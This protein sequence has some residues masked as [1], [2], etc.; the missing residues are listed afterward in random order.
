G[1]DSPRF[2]R[3]ADT[4]GAAVA[5]ASSNAFLE[6]NL[7]PK[8]TDTPSSS[9]LHRKKDGPTRK[10]SVTKHALQR[11]RLRSKSASGRDSMSQSKESIHRTS[12]VKQADKA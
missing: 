6:Q 4:T 1:R 8:L 2:N 12:S 7:H 5:Q 9:E 3:S 11:L 10:E